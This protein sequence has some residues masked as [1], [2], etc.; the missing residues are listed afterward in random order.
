MNG[1]IEAGTHITTSTGKLLPG[2]PI[3][4][5]QDPTDTMMLGEEGAPAFTAAGSLRGSTDDGILDDNFIDGTFYTNGFSARHAGGSQAL[6]CDGHAKYYMYP[7]LVKY[8]N[9]LVT[10]GTTGQEYYSISVGNT[11]T[12]TCN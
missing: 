6:F 2:L 1:C 5:I 8:S 11:Q 3:S 12:P 10:G 9:I 4:K 7:N